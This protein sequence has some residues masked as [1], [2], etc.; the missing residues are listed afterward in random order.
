[1]PPKEGV[2]RC[3]FC[4][5]EYIFPGGTVLNLS[6]EEQQSRPV[7]RT[8]DVHTMGSVRKKKICPFDI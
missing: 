5:V 3:W 4:S 1:M 6:Y 8:L 2:L 7:I